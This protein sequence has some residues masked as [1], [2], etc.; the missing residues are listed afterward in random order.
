MARRVSARSL[1]LAREA[2]AIAEELQHREWQCAARRALGL[3]ALDLFAEDEALRQL[4]TAHDIARRL[5]SAT[6]TRWTGASLATGLARSG[7][8]SRALALIDEVEQLVPHQETKA[9]EGGTKGDV[10]RATLGVR[11]LRLARGVALGS[12]GDW[13]G[14]L[15]EVRDFD[16]GNAGSIPCALLVR[17]QALAGL[18][19]WDDAT[20]ALGA[21]RRGAAQQGA[22]PLAWRIEGVHGRLLL[23]RRRRVEARRALDAAR[24]MAESLV[25]PLDEP[26]LLKHFAEGLSGEAPPAPPR[27]RAQTAKAQFGG[28]TRRERDTAALIADGRSNRAIAKALGIGERTVEGYVAAA[29][30]KLGFSSR[31]QIAVW[32]S[33]RGL[34]AGRRGTD[35]QRS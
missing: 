16:P 12:I 1:A 34:A 35:R 17:A 13:E 4:E 22:R 29:L 6:W 23:A 19:R 18:G 9:E 15:G 33:E 14:A 11:A 2:L 21:A 31:A 10:P 5:A 25:A 28:L 20:A 27:T 26:E 8:G 32:A 3:V 7:R 30:A 24:A